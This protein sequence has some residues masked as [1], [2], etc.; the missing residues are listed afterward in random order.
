MT[1]TDIPGGGGAEV[2]QGVVPFVALEDP[3]NS[4]KEVEITITNNSAN[5][6][7]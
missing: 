3:D 6:Y 4:K 1:F 7:Y 5:F 2:P